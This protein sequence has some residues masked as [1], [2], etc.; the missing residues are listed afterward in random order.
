MRTLAVVTGETAG[1]APSVAARA[2]WFLGRLADRGALD[3]VLVLEPSSMPEDRRRPHDAIGPVAVADRFLA[4]S[5]TALPRSGLLRDVHLHRPVDRRSE[6]TATD[7]LIES[8]TSSA[9]E[10]YDL[11][12]FG[13]LAAM[14][15]VRNRHRSTP[16][17]VDID[18]GADLTGT[19]S[20]RAAR[21]WA[22]AADLVTV[23]GPVRREE[24][25]VPGAL[26][27]TVTGD[28]HDPGAADAAAG[29][30]VAAIATVIDRAAAYRPVRSS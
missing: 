11:L 7:L 24:L 23:D 20:R 26:V 19:R 17:A 22:A 2:A 30:F 3:L 6:P 29:A 28:D 5:G 25:G 12:W 13:D 9:P 14:A 1:A 27:V 10:P 15:R 16:A 8:F 4:V 21:S 18:H